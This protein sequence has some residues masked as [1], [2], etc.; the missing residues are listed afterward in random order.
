MNPSSAWLPDL[1]EPPECLGARVRL[2]ATHT[3]D[4]DASFELHADPE[5]MRYWSTL[6]MQTR[7]QAEARVRAQIDSFGARQALAWAITMREHDAFIGNVTLFKIDPEH[8]RCEIG[9]SLLRAFWGSGYAREALQL[10]IAFA[11]DTLGMHRIEADID[12]RNTRSITLIERLGFQREGL[13]RERW[14]VGDEVSDTAL[15]ALLS[16]DKRP[17]AAVTTTTN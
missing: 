15:Y 12:P 16:S 7:A 13:L 4:I 10:A 3:R 1:R 8:R 2:R 11:F 9:Y 6:P 5:V 14:R 17:R